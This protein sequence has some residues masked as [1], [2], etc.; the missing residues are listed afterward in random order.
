M[1]EFLG[2]N[3]KIRG[4]ATRTKRYIA[5]SWTSAGEEVR[6]G[7]VQAGVAMAAHMDGGRQA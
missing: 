7:D 5:L 3:E 1:E 4:L 2:Q 6:D